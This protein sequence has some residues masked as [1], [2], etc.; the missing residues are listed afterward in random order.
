MTALPEFLQLEFFSQCIHALPKT[1][2]LI[3]HKFPFL[4]QPAQRFLLQHA[5]VSAQILK[6][7]RLKHHEPRV[8]RRTVLLGLFTEGA[9]RVVSADV[10]DAL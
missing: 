1:A 8:D 5:V 3:A 9:H 7:L 2:V 10:Q 6:D 4:R